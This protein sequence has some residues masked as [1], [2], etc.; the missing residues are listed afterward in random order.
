MQIFLTQSLDLNQSDTKLERCES[1]SPLKHTEAIPSINEFRT[2]NPPDPPVGHP[3]VK[4]ERST[5]SETNDTQAVA[6]PFRLYPSP[7]QQPY[8]PGYPRPMYES[9]Y[10]TQQPPYSDNPSPSGW[11]FQQLPRAPYESFSQSISP[12]YYY[13]HQQQ[14]QGYYLRNFG[15]SC[16]FDQF[17]K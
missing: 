5:P 8:W 14:Q 1:L 11:G 6:P 10:D 16:Y 2:L 15:G 4:D 7:I 13:H 17:N 3:E 12:E 9:S